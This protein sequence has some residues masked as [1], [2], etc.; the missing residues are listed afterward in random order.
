MASIGSARAGIADYGKGTGA[1]VILPKRL[2]SAALTGAHADYEHLLRDNYE[3][4][5]AA[6]AEGGNDV[7]LH[8]LAEMLQF[9][10]A[11]FKVH[12]RALSSPDELS[13]Y[14][15][16]QLMRKL[17]PSLL[18]ITLH[19]I[20][21]AH[22]GAFSLYVD[23]IR[24]SDYLCAEIWR[25]IQSNPEY[26]GNTTMFILPDFGRDSDLSPGGNGFQHHRTG[27]AVSR[28][29]WMLAIG[30]GSTRERCCRSA[31]LLDRSRTHTWSTLGLYSTFL[32]R[33]DTARGGLG[34]E[35]VNLIPEQFERLSAAREENSAR[36]FAIVTT[37]AGELPS[38]S[39]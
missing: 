7:N 32:A 10:V 8:E 27:D 35:P 31:C 1:G 20:D 24:R 26:A 28:T 16:K 37:I 30:P 34:D 25:N 33:L 21:V 6:P 5:L 17:S 11:D 36:A 3:S 38:V 15:A 23:G 12:A 29:T 13:V 18:W 9:S 22:S 4:P 39:S 19:D 14:I 2:L